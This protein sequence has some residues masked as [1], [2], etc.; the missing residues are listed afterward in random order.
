MKLKSIFLLVSTILSLGIGLT[1]TRTT[2][3]AS[4]YISG[5]QLSSNSHYLVKATKTVPVLRYT[6]GTCMAYNRSHSYKYLHKGSIVYTSRSFMSPWGWVIK[7]SNVYQ[8][9]SRTFYLI[10]RGNGKWYTRLR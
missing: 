6:T 7:S 10:A 5:I 1:A 4:R 9:T 2:V 8:P 3:H